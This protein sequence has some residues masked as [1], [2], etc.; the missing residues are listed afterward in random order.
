MTT[1]FDIILQDPNQATVCEG[2]DVA[3]EAKPS[4]TPKATGAQRARAVNTGGYTYKW[5]VTRGAQNATVRLPVISDPATPLAIVKTGGGVPFG[6]YTVTVDVTDGTEL[7]GSGT[8]DGGFEILPA[9]LTEPLAVGPVTLGRPAVGET[10]DVSFWQGLR[11]ATAQISFDA[12]DQFIN[13]VMLGNLTEPE[14]GDLGDM[15]VGRGTPFPGIDAYQLLKTA[16]EVFLTANCPVLYDYKFED[17]SALTAQN[18]RLGQNRSLKS[19]KDLWQTQYLV[20]LN[21]DTPKFYTLPYLALIRRKLGDYTILQRNPDTQSSVLRFDGIMQEALD[22][23]CFLELIWSYWHEEGMLV[24]T[25]NAIARRFQNQRSGTRDPLANFDLAPLRPLS[26]IL[27]GYIQDEQH[28]LT[29][30]R[31]AYEYDHQYGITLRGKAVPVLNA[32]DS[33]SKFIE[34]FHN[35]LTTCVTFY[36]QDDNTMVIADPFPVLNALKEVHLLLTEGQHNQFGDL[37]FNARLEMLMQQWIL[38]RTEMRDFLGGRPMVPY[39]EPWMDR[40][41]AMKKLQN[42][43]DVS[44]I[45]FNEL[46]RFGEEILLSIRHGNWSELIDSAAAANWARDFRPPVQQY[47]HAYG[48]ATG[49]HL[50]PEATGPQIVDRD[51][52]PSAHLQRRLEL[53]QAQSPAGNTTGLGRP[54]RQGASRVGSNRDGV[55][56][57]VTRPQG[58]RAEM[59]FSEDY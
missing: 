40:V 10:P 35:L 55:R 41:D 3:L 53:Q 29:V 36:K 11:G 34:A 44:I 18:A 58:T 15:Q 54:Q 4:L 32:A 37:T 14:K 48:A 46:A 16:T 12:Y 57:A 2:E 8:L 24:Q 49:V 5:N 25:L 50:A 52:Q 59:E 13:R 19:L 33:R 39:H 17:Q 42:W 38:S 6:R 22:R 9:P 21:S 20:P 31:R 30:V 1:Q 47:I 45:H 26:N 28:R 23:P 43:T 27:W 7:V 56:V 51:L